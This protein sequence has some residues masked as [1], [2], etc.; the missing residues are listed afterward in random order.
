MTR[1]R[2]AAMGVLAMAASLSG[3]TALA[4]VPGTGSDYP[5]FKG[6]VEAVTLNIAVRDR[7]GQIGRAHV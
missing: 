1:F 5:V 4:Q 7:D 3:P 2:H 6:G